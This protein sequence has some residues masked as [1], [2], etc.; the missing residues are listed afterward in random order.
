MAEGSRAWESKGKAEGTEDMAGSWP[1][2][3]VPGGSGLQQEERNRSEGL[4]PKQTFSSHPPAVVK[5]AVYL[6]FHKILIIYTNL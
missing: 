5:I 6:F 3:T 4:M 1:G 2:W